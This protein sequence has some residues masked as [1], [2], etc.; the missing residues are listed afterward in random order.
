[1]MWLQG[2]AMCRDDVMHA[3]QGCDVIVHAVNPPGYRR[4]AELVLPM[5]DNTIAAAIA[6][7]ATI[8]LPGTVYNY[9]PDAFPL[10]GKMRRNVR[11]PARAPSVSNWNA[12]F[13][14]PAFVGRAPLLSGPAIS[15]ARTRATTGLPKGW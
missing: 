9:G 6:Q 5:M 1:M 15:L 10:I 2:D 8:V 14:P 3:A 7:G 12:G 4:W 11:S 13:R